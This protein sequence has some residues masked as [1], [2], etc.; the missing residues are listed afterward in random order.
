MHSVPLSCE[1][2]FHSWQNVLDYRSHQCVHIS[3]SVYRFPLVA[4]CPYLSWWH[5]VTNVV[6]GHV[7]TISV[8]SNVYDFWWWHYVLIFARGHVFSIS[9]G[10]NVYDFGWWYCV[11]IFIRGNVFFIFAGG[12]LYSIQLYVKMFCQVRV[13]VSGHHTSEI[14]NWTLSVLISKATT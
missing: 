14:P 9:A 4:M 1:I 10:G 7:F 5:C 3:A 8:G 13:R 11:W 2:D 6:R 12:I